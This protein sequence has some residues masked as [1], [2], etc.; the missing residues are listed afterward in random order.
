MKKMKYS[1]G[2]KTQKIN[3]S[4]HYKKQNQ[5]RYNTKYYNEENKI[6]SIITGHLADKRKGKDTIGNN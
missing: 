4:V 3:T 1:I 5:G 2:Y 6:W